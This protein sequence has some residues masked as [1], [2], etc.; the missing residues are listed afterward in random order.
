MRSSPPATIAEFTFLFGVALFPN[1]IDSTLGP[2]N[3]LTIYNAAPSPRTLRL[4]LVIAGLGMPFVLS[5]TAVVYWVFRG[6]VQLG[7]LS[8]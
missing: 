3:N 8:Y 5:Y 6:K 4:M 1:I 2:A 7:K